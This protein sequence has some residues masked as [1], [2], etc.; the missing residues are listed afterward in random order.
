MDKFWV[1][2]NPRGFVPRVQHDSIESATQEAE[3]LADS[4]PRDMFYVLEALTVSRKT[5]VTTRPL[6]EFALPF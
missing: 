2:W 3:R 4:N 1:V 5:S 6:E